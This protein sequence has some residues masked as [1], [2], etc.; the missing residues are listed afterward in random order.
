[1][2]DLLDMF[3]HTLRRISDSVLFVAYVQPVA[4]CL[5]TLSSGEVT[6]ILPWP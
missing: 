5:V 4:G 6:G 3:L 2:V 1:M